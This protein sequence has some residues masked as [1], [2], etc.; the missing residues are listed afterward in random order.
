LAISLNQLPR[1][2]QVL[3][4]TGRT[5]RPGEAYLNALDAEWIPQ[6]KLGDAQWFYCD[7]IPNLLPFAFS[8]GHDLWCWRLDVP[9]GDREYEIIFAPRDSEEGDRY[10]PTFSTWAFRKA[11]EEATTFWDPEPET[12]ARLAAW[13][14]VLRDLGHT[15]LAGSIEEIDARP[16]REASRGRGSTYRSWQF[17]IEPEEYEQLVSRFVGAEYW[18]APIRWM[19]G[20]EAA[21]D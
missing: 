16:L 14:S 8:G 11:L 12:R 1:D 15:E 20:D 13:A 19:A 4:A 9:T 5:T 10:A 7:P 6:A 18:K 17:L 2:Y 21:A 3:V